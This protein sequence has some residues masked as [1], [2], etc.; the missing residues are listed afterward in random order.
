MNRLP[1]ILANAAAVLSLLA[2]LLVLF[3]WVASY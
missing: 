3:L 2:F 1:R